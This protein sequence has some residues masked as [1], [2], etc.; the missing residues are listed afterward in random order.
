MP[1]QRPKP[2]ER[3]VLGRGLRVLWSY[4][5]MHLLPFA[6]SVAGATL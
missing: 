3:G 1:S 5:R 6:I 4:V 2:S